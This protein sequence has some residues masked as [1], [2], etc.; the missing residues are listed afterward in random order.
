ML[1]PRCRGR[2]VRR[3]LVD[4]VVEVTV[5]CDE[6]GCHAGEIQCCEGDRADP[7]LPEGDEAV[8]FAETH[9]EASLTVARRRPSGEGGA[10]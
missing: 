8:R 6:P 5:P 1:C 7:C 10:P 9:P 2:G 3:V 4:T